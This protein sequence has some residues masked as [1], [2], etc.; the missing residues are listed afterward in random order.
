M[1]DN[2]DADVDDEGLEAVDNLV[3][4]IDVGITA[5]MIPPGRSDTDDDGG[6]IDSGSP[7]DEN[8]CAC[9]YDR[10]GDAV[11]KGLAA[12]SSREGI[13]ALKGVSAR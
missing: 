3:V 13:V 7:D 10:N 6:R 2:D 8:E 9:G 11:G 12:V 1:L 4:D 5:V